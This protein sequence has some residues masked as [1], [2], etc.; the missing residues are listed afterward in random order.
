[1]V[2]LLLILWDLFL[3]GLI[4]RITGGSLVFGIRYWVLDILFECI[5]FL[6]LFI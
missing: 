3:F 4:E 1:M 5:R 2:E 6:F